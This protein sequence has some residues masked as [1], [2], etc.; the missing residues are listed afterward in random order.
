MTIDLNMAGTAKGSYTLEVAVGVI[1]KRLMEMNA[2][3]TME[4]AGQSTP[5]TMKLNMDEG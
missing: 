3:G 5:F 2:T 4:V 1:R